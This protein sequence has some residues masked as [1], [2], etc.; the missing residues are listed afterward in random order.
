LRMNKKIEAQKEELTHTLEQLQKAHQKLIES[1]KMAA[2]GQVI[3][4]IAH[5]L[6]TPLGS[7]HSSVTNISH[8][9]THTL[10]KLPT[11]FQSLTQEHQQDFLVLLQKSMQPTISLSSKEKRQHR[12]VLIQKLAQHDIDN[13]ENIA[14]TLVEIGIA[15]HIEPLLPLL[16]DAHGMNALNLSYQLAGLQKN[17][18]TLSIASKRVSKVIFALKSFSRQEQKNRWVQA[19]LTDGIETVLTLYYHQTIQGVTI[20]RNYSQLPLVFCIPE[21]MNQVWM[22]L[23]LNSLQAMNNKGILQI[24]TQMNGTEVLIKIT[25]NGTGIPEQIQPYI[26]NTFFTTK[27]V[28]EG[29]GLGLN[30]VKKIM[31]KHQGQITFTSEPGKTTFSIHLPLR[32]KD[33]QNNE[34]A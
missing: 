4:N 17:A 9:L 8:F 34:N 15:Q 12:R 16:K 23:I 29:S 33:R 2:L 3:A 25:D 18:K 5:E 32:Q 19:N 27:Q 21:E 26:F 7:I 24:D 20:V 31:E 10:E 30:I 14:D 11:F 6:N 28:G 1:E 13:A 22:N